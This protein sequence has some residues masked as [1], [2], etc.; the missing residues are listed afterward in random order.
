MLN[1]GETFVEKK[2]KKNVIGGER[3]FILVSEV[4][5]CGKCYTRSNFL[6]NFSVLVERE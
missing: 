3:R 5:G 2:K 4:G 6:L 1:G